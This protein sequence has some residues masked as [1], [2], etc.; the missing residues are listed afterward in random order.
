MG[1]QDW[2]SATNR[3]RLKESL[4]CL[5]IDKHVL[6]DP[7]FGIQCVFLFWAKKHKV[8]HLV[9][10]VYPVDPEPTGRRLWIFPLEQNAWF[11]SVKMAHNWFPISFSR[12]VWDLK[13]D[14]LGSDSKLF[15]Y[16][17]HFLPEAVGSQAGPKDVQQHPPFLLTSPAVINSSRKI[18]VKNRWGTIPPG[19]DLEVVFLY[20]C[21]YEWF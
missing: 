3:T 2:N 17:A 15:R 8:L 13:K 11:F 20:S 9:Q 10:L 6:K 19:K 14:P 7:G 21:T 16:S 18:F 5:R 12:N 1:D 4:A